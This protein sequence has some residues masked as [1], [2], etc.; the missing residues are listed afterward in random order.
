ML[1]ILYLLVLL[2]LALLRAY[3]LSEL[4]SSTPNNSFLPLAPLT[5]WN[6]RGGD[7]TPQEYPNFVASANIGYLND[8]TPSGA[9]ALDNLIS[10]YGADSSSIA[11]SQPAHRHDGYCRDSLPNKLCCDDNVGTRQDQED[12]RANCEICMLPPTFH[13]GWNH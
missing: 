8:N 11:P 12:L 4:G 13:V 10:L 2:P 9:D 5:E 7:R 6:G 1:F 3:P